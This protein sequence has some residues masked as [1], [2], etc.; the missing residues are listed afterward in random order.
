MKFFR[1]APVFQVF[2]FILIAFS[3]LEGASL[4]LLYFNDFHG[5]AESFAPYGA[6]ET[7]GGAAFLAARAQELRK[8]KPSLFLAAGDVMQGNNWSNLSRGKAAIELLNLMAVDVLVV[9]NHEFDFGLEVLRERVSEAKF[10][11]LGANVE[12]FKT[13]LPYVIREVNGISVAILGVVTDDTPVAT[14]PRHVAGLTFAKPAE[15]VQYYLPELRRRADLVVVLSHLGYRAD[16]ELAAQVPGIDLIVGGH[17]HTR[18]D[19]PTRIGDTLIVQ[20][21]EHGKALGVLD[22]RLEGGKIVSHKGWL[23]DIGPRRGTADPAVASLVEKYRLQGETILQGRAGGTL[24]ALDGENVRRRETNL[25]NLVADIMKETSG[26][27]AAIINGG[28][29]RAGIPVGP[30]LVKDI[31]NILPFDLYLVAV[32]LRG[33]ALRKALEHGV[34]RVEEGSGAF[35]QV[36]G[37]SFAYRP[38]APPGKRVREVRVGGRPLDPMREYTVATN[39]FLAAGGDG[40]T[41][42]GDAVR[43]SRDFALIGGTMKGEKLVY[44]DAGRWLRDLVIEWLK[45]KNDINPKV[46]NRI[47]EVR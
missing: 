42:F 31:Y 24:A 15:T 16:R 19:H 4:R 47:R 44:S 35:P 17:S 13:L 33:S 5:Y 45:E 38:K 30:I 41:V 9:G 28:G 8:E 14:H 1:F 10:P 18:I 32:R 6:K 21:W 12:G 36:S 2:A 27:D 46:E 25:G 34:A 39:D 11:V 43:S 26:A 23:E 40:Y 37:L 29:L 22:L 20:A 7:L 3:P